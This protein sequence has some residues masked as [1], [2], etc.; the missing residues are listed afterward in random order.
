M[1]FANKEVWEQVDKNWR[2]GVEMIHSNFLSILAHHGVEPY[3]PHNEQFDPA[4]HES[5]KMI[6]TDKQE[7]DQQIVEVLQSGYRTK[8]IIIRPA[9]VNVAIYKKEL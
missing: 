8:D 3:A 2:S 7:Q 4:L 1:A 9:K 6:P 5:I